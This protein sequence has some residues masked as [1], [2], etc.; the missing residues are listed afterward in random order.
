MS[1]P[2][3]PTRGAPTLQ[4]SRRRLCRHASAR[5]GHLVLRSATRRNGPL[6]HVASQREAFVDRFADSANL[7][8]VSNYVK[9]HA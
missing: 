1:P 4:S 7:L 8:R 6:S 5:P 3:A 2:W 9:L